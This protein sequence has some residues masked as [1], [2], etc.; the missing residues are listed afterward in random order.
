MNITIQLNDEQ[1]NAIAFTYNL[2]PTAVLQNLIN[3]TVATWID[4]MNKQADKELLIAVKETPKLLDQAQTA[5]AT[6]AELGTIDLS[7]G[8]IIKK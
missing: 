1:V 5:V 3:E 8:V 2:D 7:G 4:G 6:K